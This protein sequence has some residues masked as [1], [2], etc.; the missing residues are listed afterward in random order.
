MKKWIRKIKQWWR[1]RQFR[2]AKPITAE[3]RDYL[4]EAIKQGNKNPV[5]R[6]KRDRYV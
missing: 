1:S 5:S 4:K 6:A 3:R 2:Q